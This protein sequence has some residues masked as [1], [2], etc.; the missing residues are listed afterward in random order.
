MAKGRKKHHKRRSRHRRSVIAAGVL[1]GAVILVVGTAV[2]TGRAPQE[3]K[4]TLTAWGDRLHTVPSGHLPAFAASASS[5]VQTVYRYAVA[6][7][8]ILQYIPCFCGCRNIGHRHNGDCYVRARHADG[9]I[10][11]TSHGGT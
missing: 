7:P 8:G 2:W 5:S 6:H 4:V 10:T 11:Y 1:V 9:T 3:D